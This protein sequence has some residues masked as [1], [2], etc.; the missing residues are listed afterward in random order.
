MTTRIRNIFLTLICA[1]LLLPPL[2]GLAQRKA[3]FIIL[4]G[5]SADIVEKL[6]TPALDEIADIGGY[7]RAYVG[8]EKNRYSE[9]PTVSA[10]G[11]NHLLTGVWSNKHNVYDNDIEAPNYHYWNI[12][13][14]AETS[15]PG[16]HSAIFS[17]WLDNRTKLIG[18]GLPQAGNIKLD[19]A[20]DGFEHNQEKF[21]PTK[22]RTFMFDI[23]EHV[24]KGAAR[25]IGEEGPDLSW[26]YLQFTDDMGH[27]YGD[28]PQYFDAVK[29]A[30]VQVSR[31]W[32]AVKT[33]QKTTE[34]EWMIVV[35]TDHGRRRSTG[36]GHGGQT[37]R[38]R[39]IWITT[40][41]SDLNGR[42]E[43]TPAITD[44]MPTIM[45]FMDIEIP[46]ETLE[47]LDGIP[48]TGDISIANLKAHRKRHTITLTWDVFNPG[49]D[50][51][52]MVTTTDNFKNGGRDEYVSAGTAK[53]SNGR[54]RYKIPASDTGKSFFK[55]RVETPSN[56]ATVWCFGR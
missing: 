40:N 27:M 1:F 33:R 53:V 17:S 4:D 18:E 38:E 13:R 28:K 7:A 54:F 16:I 26:V 51:R 24:S 47:E 10:V 6:E 36:K 34:E 32:E 19:Y 14:I 52:I 30:D 44:I 2:H 23:D 22:D 48:F 49:G 29:K 15:K 39:T 37:H 5:I 9:S 11:Y 3:V 20:F 56:M 25:Y 41:L 46:E 55:I 12:F 50:A 42:F 43:Q 21:P 8:G 35:T 45:R 31:I